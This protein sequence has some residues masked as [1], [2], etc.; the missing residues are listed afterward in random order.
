MAILESKNFSEASN[1]AFKPAE[2]AASS[3]EELKSTTTN[4][5]NNND[6]KTRYSTMVQNSEKE[7]EILKQDVDKEVK[8]LLINSQISL[9]EKINPISEDNVEN[10]KT[11]L[12]KLI[13]K[14]GSEYG[15]FL[16]KNIIECNNSKELF[17]VIKN[18][19]LNYM[20]S[21]YEDRI[22]ELCNLVKTK[23]I[24]SDEFDN[25][26][27]E[28]N[29][30]SIVFLNKVVELFMIKTTR[31]EVFKLEE[32]VRNMGVKY[33]RFSNDLEQAI[34]IK[35]AIA[36]LLK[37]KIQLPES[38][39]VTPIIPMGKSGYNISANKTDKNIGNIFIQTSYENKFDDFLKKGV[40]ELAYHTEIFKKSSSMNRSKYVSLYNNL[41][42]ISSTQNSKHRIYH[43]I[44]HSFCPISLE[45]I[46]RELSAEEMNVAKSV[47]KYAARSTNGHE[48]V[49]EIFAKLMDKQKLTK[50][51]MELYLKLGGIVPQI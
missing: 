35:E 44:A 24:S 40:G 13:V 32:E 10:I 45:A 30:N 43:V 31:P 49:P 47:S 20:H 37:A 19:L 38:I 6:L 23:K 48:L 9:Y 21:T 51:Q 27:F 41:G 14:T 15:E 36:D 11:A 7:F 50:E 33:V 17:C 1:E 39:I 4:L 34:L 25:I 2:D 18:V 28:L 5:S 29:N 16:I 22:S 42:K 8:C 12:I 3:L 26:I 46:M